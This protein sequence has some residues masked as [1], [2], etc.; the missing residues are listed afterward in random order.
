MFKAL[1]F[2]LLLF[3]TSAIAEDIPVTP[4]P[5]PQSMCMNYMDG[6]AFFNSKGFVVLM[7]GRMSEEAGI[8]VYYN[9]ESTKTIF[10][11]VKIIENKPTEMCITALLPK[12]KF[13]ED[14]IKKLNLHFA[15][16]V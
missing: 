13:N 16:P 11:L 10:A 14:F 7:G 1:L 8:E 2:S 9:M 12:T 6:S 4:K 5:A 3:S 15:H